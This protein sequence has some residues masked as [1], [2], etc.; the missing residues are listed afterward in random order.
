MRVESLERFRNKRIA[1][2]F[3]EFARQKAAATS[4][5]VANALRAEYAEFEL[6]FTRKEMACMERIKNR[7]PVLRLV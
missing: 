6:E 1:G 2:E 7:K 5:K 3:V 4:E